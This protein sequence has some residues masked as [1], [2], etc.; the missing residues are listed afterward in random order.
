LGGR[1]VGEKEWS[2][3]KKET[4][5]G[6]EQKKYIGTKQKNRQRQTKGESG[7]CKG[8]TGKGFQGKPKA[9]SKGKKQKGQ[10]GE[11]VQGKMKASKKRSGDEGE[12]RGGC[13]P[14]KRKMG[15]LER[16]KKKKRPEGKRSR[17]GSE[18]ETRKGH[19]SRKRWF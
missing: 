17:R 13:F 7:W 4:S 14:G 18:T 9:K 3:E 19:V 12:P 5:G 15:L 1:G 8:S 16:G 11:L 2:A 10:H 6:K